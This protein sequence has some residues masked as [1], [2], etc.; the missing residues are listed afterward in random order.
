MGRAMR[1]ALACIV[2]SWAVVA[3]AA[4][5]WV[6]GVG[7]YAYWAPD[8]KSLLVR[9]YEGDALER[10]DETG[11]LKPPSVA[12]RGPLFDNKFA[13]ASPRRGGRVFNG[14]KLLY[15]DDRGAWVLSL[16]PP[17]RAPVAKIDD[18]VSG[19]EWLDGGRILLQGYPDAFIVEGGAKRRIC[20]KLP[21][22]ETVRAWR[23]G[24]ALVVSTKTEV[25]IGDV[26]CG[27]LKKLV[28]FAE[29]PVVEA[30]PS[31]KETT[32]AVV[33][34][35]KDDGVLWLMPISGAAK[36][37]GTIHGRQM[38]WLDD[39]R[40]A[41]TRGR[42]GTLEV[43]AVSADGSTTGPLLEPKPGCKDTDPSLSPTGKQ[44]AVMRTCSGVRLALIPIDPM[45]Q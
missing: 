12:L 33:R 17:S 36:R 40:L 16:S 15:A 44:L 21:K 45:T 38:V 14:K 20:E 7:G 32:I 43:V 10:V 31:P 1:I 29:G 2:S 11:K 22:L 19:V 18:A 34:V 25:S 26:G 39:T 4:P 5:L 35:E 3:Q 9:S 41:Y 27:H 23:N 37:I 24:R 8:G 28:S 6:E 42:P 30:L 13:L